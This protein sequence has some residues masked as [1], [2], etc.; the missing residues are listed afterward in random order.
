MQTDAEPR[1]PG[2]SLPH[3]GV[4]SGARARPRAPL[5]PSRLLPGHLALGSTSLVPKTD[6]LF[7]FRATFNEMTSSPHSASKL[8]SHNLW[9]PPTTHNSGPLT[10]MPS[11]GG[12][13]S[14]SA[15]CGPASLSR[16]AVQKHRGPGKSMA[17]LR[18]A[19]VEKEV[20]QGGLGSSEC[21]AHG[22]GR[23]AGHWL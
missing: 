6:F 15:H 20:K 19:S 2:G 14:R 16:P 18:P 12:S 22:E 8:Q 7:P 9:I 17:R 13:D 11:A 10:D 23:C 5:P 1:H 4:P 3:L 21:P